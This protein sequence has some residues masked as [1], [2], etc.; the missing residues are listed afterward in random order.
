MEARLYSIDTSRMN[1]SQ[2]SSISRKIFGHKTKKR[3]YPTLFSEVEIFSIKKG[4]G[5]FIVGIKYTKLFEDFLIENKIPFL[6]FG[7]LKVSK[8]GITE[9]K[10][11]KKNDYKTNYTNYLLET[12]GEKSK[13]EFRKVLIELLKSRL[14]NTPKCT[15]S[16]VK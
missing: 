4:V 12:R 2:R 15:K 13:D 10:K 11:A 9:L 14:K 5:I 3:E 1:P 8:K 16:K 7:Q 6:M